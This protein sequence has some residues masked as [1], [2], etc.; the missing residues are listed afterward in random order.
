MLKAML[1]KLVERRDLTTDEAF[2][3]IS[4]LT[5]EDVPD[6]LAGALLT[7]LSMKGECIDELVGGAEVLRR[8]ALAINCAGRDVVDVVG[9]GGDHGATFNISTTSAIAA[10]AAGVPIAKHGNRAA[11]GKCGAADVLEAL[12]FNLDVRPGIMEDAIARDGLGFLFAR[13]LHPI[14]GKV[15]NLRRELGVRT[16]F[17]LLGPLANPAGA[18]LMLVGVYDA[19]LTEIYAHALRRLGVRRALIVHGNDGLDEI[20][21]CETTRVT[22]L[23]DGF[24]KSYELYPEMLLGRTYDPKELEGGDAKQNARILRD[25]LSGTERGAKRAAVLLNTAATCYVAGLCENL[26]DGIRLAEN[27]I[28]SGAAVRKLDTLLEVSHK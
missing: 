24:L 11:S 19:P 13:K 25:V 2:T 23:K 26:H 18:S 5:R 3:L 4:T 17:N 15:A 12:G 21:C 16:I 9:T 14:L 1:Q 22:E 6:G 20:T 7:A 28:D 10:A 27:A 8:S